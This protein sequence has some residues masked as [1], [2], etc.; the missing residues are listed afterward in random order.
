VVFDLALHEPLIYDIISLLKNKE[1]YMPI[2]RPLPNE[3]NGFK[4]LEDL[5]Q[6]ANKIRY[7]LVVCKACNKEFKTSVYHIKKIGSC[8][9]LPCKPPAKDLPEIIN[10]FRILKDFGYS[11]GSR[12]AL[13]ICKVCNKEYEV[14]P[15]KLIYRKHCGCMRKGVIASR[16]NKQY[17]RLGQTYKH[18]IGR[19]Y[20]NTDQDY[21]NYGARGITVCDEWKKDRNVF[22]EWALQ[23]GYNDNLT[24]DRID[25]NK[26]YYP[27]NCRWA[28][29]SDQARNTNRNVMT[30]DL[31]NKIR[32]EFNNNARELASR[33]DVSEG[34]IFNILHNRSW[35]E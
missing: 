3:I 34:T 25:F 22:I 19:C 6:A 17:P 9:C 7:A 21:Y 27:E 23:N 35:K 13:V 20:K 16:Y 31:A 8:G 11:N 26:G 2:T 18:M 33:Y 28:T 15:N 24:I 30:M 1:V 32:K 29:A 5:G 10:G 14:D 4:V 12:R